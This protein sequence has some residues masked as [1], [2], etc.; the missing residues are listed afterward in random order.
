M[1]KKAI[2]DEEGIIFSEWSYSVT[3]APEPFEI[4]ELEE[5]MI[6]SMNKARPKIEDFERRKAQSLLQ[7]SKM[8]RWK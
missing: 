1:T 7:A 3:N 5:K 6:T 4:E 2:K 8:I